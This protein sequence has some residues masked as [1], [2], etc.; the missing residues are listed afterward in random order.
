[1]RWYQPWFQ[2]VL[3]VCA[4][5]DKKYG[6]WQVCQCD[7]MYIKIRENRSLHWTDQWVLSCELIPV[8]CTHWEW[9]PT[10]KDNLSGGNHWVRKWHKGVSLWRSKRSVSPVKKGPNSIRK[11]VT[12]SNND[13]QVKIK[14]WSEMS[15]LDVP[16]GQK[17]TF[18][19][20]KTDCFGNKISLGSTDQT[21]IEPVLVSTD[22]KHFTIDGYDIDGQSVEP[23]ARQA[24]WP[25]HMDGSVVLAGWR[26]HAPH[27]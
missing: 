15:Q 1:M 7:I 27:T 8:W 4:E 12:V 11:E 9:I 2:T 23:P 19:N 20:V 10:I 5:R 3:P 26:Q 16:I 6:C 18:V 24:A 21:Y 14:L 17:V 13:R 25:P 22:E